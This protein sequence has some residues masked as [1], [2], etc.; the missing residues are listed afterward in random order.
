MLPKS[1]SC[2]YENG[3]YVFFNKSKIIQELL[4]FSFP[5]FLNREVEIFNVFY[6][7]S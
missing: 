4:F 5:Y 2:I 6:K 1:L 3:T 7:A